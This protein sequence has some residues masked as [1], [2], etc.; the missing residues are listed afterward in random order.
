VI[1]AE[2]AQV[3]LALNNAHQAFENWKNAS[4]DFRA[5]LLLKAAA[6]MESRIQE[7]MVYCVVKVVKPMQCHCRS[8]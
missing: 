2:T 3:D 8:T 6:I 4:Q 7:L 1:E 5:E